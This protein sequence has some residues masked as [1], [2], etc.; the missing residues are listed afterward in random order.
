M[1]ERWKLQQ[2]YIQEEEDIVGRYLFNNKDIEE[3]KREITSFWKR[4]ERTRKERDRDRETSDKGQ[5]QTQAAEHIM[6]CRCQGQTPNPT[7][8]LNCTQHPRDN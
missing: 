3:A 8:E 2:P 1:K 5:T 4:R 7:T 6:E